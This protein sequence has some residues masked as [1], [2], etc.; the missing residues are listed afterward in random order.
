MTARFSTSNWH[1]FI[2]KLNWN[3][4][5]PLTRASCDLTPFCQYN[6]S[7]ALSPAK[8]THQCNVPADRTGSHVILAVWEIADTATKQLTTMVA[9]SGDTESIRPCEFQHTTPPPLLI[10]KAATLPQYPS[11]IIE[12]LDYARRQDGSRKTQQ[13]N[14]SD[15]L[16]VNIGFKA[17]RAASP[18]TWTPV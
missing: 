16:A 18:S 10:L 9:D 11:L 1:F 15:R 13:I 14:T 7:D 4:S 17:C 2:T 8:V 12:A 6:D 3:A 5:Q